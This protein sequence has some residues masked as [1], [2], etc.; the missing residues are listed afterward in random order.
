[1]GLLFGSLF[2]RRRRLGPFLV[3][4]VLLDVGAGLVYVLARDRLPALFG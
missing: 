1:M 4:H 3:A 2:V